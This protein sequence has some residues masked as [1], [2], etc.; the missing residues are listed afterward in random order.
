MAARIHELRAKR[1][2]VKKKANAALL[3]ARAAAKK[4][5]RD[6]TDGEKAEQD[7]F[8]AQLKAIDADLDFEIRVL[9]RERQYG[10]ELP[11]EGNEPPV[12]G[13]GPVPEP[14]AQAAA[15][16]KK[17]LS[18]GEHLG[19]VVQAGKNPRFH[20]DRIYMA[21]GAAESVDSDGGYLVGQDNGGV[22][23]SQVYETG[24]LVGKVRKQPIGVG[25]NGFKASFLDETNRANGSRFGGLQ[26]FTQ[27]EA[28]DFS[29]KG[30]RPKFR[31]FEL[32]LLKFIGLMFLTDELMED[33]TALEGFVNEWFPQEFA[34][35]LDDNIFAGNGAGQ[36]VGMINSPARVT[37]AKEV[38]QPAKTVQAE[39]IEKMYA[40]MP[41]GSLSNAEFF[42]NQEVW[43]QL[44]K[45]SHAIGTGGV[46]MFVPAGG[47]SVAPFGTLLGRPIT[48]IE[49]ASA[50][51]T[52]GDVAFVDPTRYMMIDKG[53]IKTAAS[54]HVK[55]LTDEQALRWTLRANGQP[56]AAAPITPYKGDA[57]FKMSSIVTLAVRA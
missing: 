15:A 43:P 44:F 17:P 50:L 27:A 56:I 24:I 26:V 13:A 22:L 23:Q 5:D 18:L 47:L 45:L 20:D 41:A 57:A 35:K 40:A 6:L 12:P 31:L 34:F 30:T 11:A 37:I 46:P 42:I 52:E 9:A 33:V 8:D 2:E 49:Q 16:A 25:S 36:F 39:N 51:G 21:S 38:G 55:F 4:E 14:A 19:L 48:P 10:S 3:A 54:I 32:L 28:Q 1:E 29:T 53:P 7:A